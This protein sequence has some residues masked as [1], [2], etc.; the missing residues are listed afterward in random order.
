M[1]KSYEQTILS[2]FSGC[3]IRNFIVNFNAVRI[4]VCGGEVDIKST[5]CKSFRHKIF[6]YTAAKVDFKIIHDSLIMAEAFKNYYRNNYSD[7]LTFEADIA[8]LST[9]ILIF[10]EAPGSLVEFGLYCAKP[11]FFNKL[12][13]V[14]PQQ[15]VEQQDSFIYLGPLEFIKSKVD[16][17]VLVYPFQDKSCLYKDDYA[18]DVCQT[19]LNKIHSGNKTGKFEANNSGHLALLIFELIRLC[20]PIQQFEIEKVLKSLGLD[21]VKQGTLKRLIY[22]LKEMDYIDSCGISSNTYFYP[23]LKVKE[24]K[25]ISFSKSNGGLDSTSIKIKVL[26][27]INLGG[28]LLAH[29]RKMAVEQ[30]SKIFEDVNNGY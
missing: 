20:F 26:E 5:T 15:H 19:I 21:E 25:A 12:I 28:D 1:G 11:E 30:I 4:F 17:S 16:D 8:N 14:V 6:E 29:R 27:S 24:N 13:I 9:L 10:L 3:D 23:K 7:L 22:L 2:I 18:E